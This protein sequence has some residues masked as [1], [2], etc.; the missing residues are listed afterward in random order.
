MI[1]R[2]NPPFRNFPEKIEELGIGGLDKEFCDL[3][4]RVFL[5]R[6]FPPSALEAMGIKPVRGKIF[7]I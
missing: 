4:R 6:L 3:Y 1:S 5:P 2:Y 7:E